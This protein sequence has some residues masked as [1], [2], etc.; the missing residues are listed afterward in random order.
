MSTSKDRSEVHL[1]MLAD[2]PLSGR[3]WAQVSFA[4]AELRRDPAGF[5]RALA[6]ADVLDRRSRRLLWF[7]RLGVPAASGFGFALGVALFAI[8]VGV[9]PATTQASP[10]P[11]IRIYPIAPRP[12]SPLEPSPQRAAGG[13]GGGDNDPRPV[14]KGVPPPSSL[15][16]PVTTATTK[17]V[18]RSLDPLPVP[19]PIKAPPVTI[20]DAERYGDPT[21][22]IA[23]PSDGPGRDGGAGAGKHGGWGPDDGPGEG[24]GDEGGRR[25][26]KFVPGSELDRTQ[27]VATKAVILNAPRPNYT[28]EARQK[29]TAGIISIRALLGADGRVKRATVERGLPDGLNERAI[30]AVSRLAFRPARDREGRP[31]DSWVVVKVA[32]TIR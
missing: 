21:S 22:N 8:F 29:K 13:G 6:S 31:V 23:D 1:T 30:E 26:G 25:D 11:Q 9:A 17:D 12:L 16:D 5:V 3:V 18:A 4:A 20:P 32:F 15:A 27:R 24:P 10:T 2:E 19:P 14:S 28:D 7:I